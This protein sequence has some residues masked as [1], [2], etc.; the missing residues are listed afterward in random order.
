[1]QLTLQLN[2]KS[3]LTIMLPDLAASPSFIYKLINNNS[4]GPFFTEIPETIKC[5]KI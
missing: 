2:F 1:M 4:A 5:R 3:E